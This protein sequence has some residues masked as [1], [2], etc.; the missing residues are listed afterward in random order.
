MSWEGSAC[1]GASVFLRLRLSFLLVRLLLILKEGKKRRM[2]KNY[3][4]V[5]QDQEKRTKNEHKQNTNKTQTKHKTKKTNKRT[6]KEQN[7][8]RKNKEN[9]SNNTVRSG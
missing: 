3:N 8:H 4:D 2:M 9:T 6:T 7:K 1:S 5:Q